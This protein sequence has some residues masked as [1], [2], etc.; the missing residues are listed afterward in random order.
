MKITNKWALSREIKKISIIFTVSIFAI[1]LSL[2]IFFLWFKF[3]D[4]RSQEIHRLEMQSNNFGKII[5]NNPVIDNMINKLWDDEMP[6]KRFN[7]LQLKGWPDLGNWPKR[8]RLENFF[9]YNDKWEI[10]FSPMKDDDFYKE[11]LASVS[12]KNWEDFKY[13]WVEY[14][15]IKK[16]LTTNTSAM[17]F[18]ESRFTFSDSLKE[19]WEYIFFAILLALLIYYITYKFV[20]RSLKPVEENIADMEQFIHN[21]WHELKTPISVIKSHLEL[22]QLKKDYKE[23]VKESIKELDRMNDLIQV[24]ISLSTIN[25][26]AENSVINVGETIKDV[27]KNYAKQIDDKHLKIEIEENTDCEIKTNKE[28]FKILFGNIFSN[29]IKYNKP[30]WKINVIINK[31][32]L[33]IKDNWIWINKDNLDKIFD[34]FYQESESREINSFWIWLSLVRKIA[35][36]Y[37]WKIEVKSQ[38]WIWTS[39]IINFS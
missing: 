9:I 30:L 3:I 5:S 1:I 15:F 27:V 21:S 26:T 38:K 11:I 8:V 7:M 22:S 39:F 16:S 10:I 12:D 29:A 33:E 32:S 20:W 13:N 24:L 23:W 28:Y 37:W 36:I 6:D 31:D 14:F 17:F 18:V 34:R 35:D 25:N 19:L 4:Y 2:E